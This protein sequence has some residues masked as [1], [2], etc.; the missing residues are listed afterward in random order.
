MLPGWLYCAAASLNANPLC[1]WLSEGPRLSRF[2]A[3]LQSKQDVCSYIFLILL[4]PWLLLVSG[5]AQLLVPHQ[6]NSPIILHSPRE[7]H[8]SRRRGVLAPVGAAAVPWWREEISE[9][10]KVSTRQG[11]KCEINS[12]SAEEEKHHPSGTCCL[13]YISGGC[14]QPCRCREGVISEQSSSLGQSSR[15]NV[16]LGNS[17]AHSLFTGQNGTWSQTQSWPVETYIA[18]QDGL[19]HHQHFSFSW[20]GPK[21]PRD[22][23]SQAQS[24]WPQ[25]VLGADTCRSSYSRGYQQTAS[26]HSPRA[27][28][29]LFQPE[30]Q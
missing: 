7:S 13:C 10:Q 1:L 14:A 30:L 23:L 2:S 3:S 25:C 4:L 28:G 19:T 11:K 17:R 12:S 8:C 18:E 26:S 16:G 6:G 9:V 15:S 29:R 22:H 24:Q 20:L 27:Q 5:L 21:L